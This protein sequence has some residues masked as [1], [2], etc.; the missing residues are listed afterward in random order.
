MSHI[1]RLR[2]KIELVA[3]SM[4][5]AI[6]AFWAHPRVQELFSRASVH[7]LLRRPDHRSAP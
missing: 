1:R 5:R 6:E 4:H 2:E 3:P 7:N